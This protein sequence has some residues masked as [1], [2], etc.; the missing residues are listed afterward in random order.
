MTKQNNSPT[1]FFWNIVDAELGCLPNDYR[2]NRP[3]LRHSLQSVVN[4]FENPNTQRFLS[5]LNDLPSGG[6][7]LVSPIDGAVS[8]QCDFQLDESTLKRLNPW[9]KGP[10]NINGLKIDAEWQSHIKWDRFSPYLSQL[11]NARVLDIGCG[12]GYYMFRMLEHNPLSVLGID[13]SHLTMFQFLAIQQFIQSSILHY[14]PIGWSDLDAF[15]FFFDVVFC[16]GIMY[17]HRSPM[18]LLETIRSIGAPGGTLFFD[19]LIMDGTDEFALFPKG[20]YAKMPNVYFIPTMVCLKNMLLRSG[21]SK[22][23]VL[24]IDRTT[25]EEQRATR[26]TSEH[27]L[28]HFL[29]PKDRKKTVEGYPAPLRIALFATL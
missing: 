28:E 9:R 22:I 21:F 29:D 19:T 13:P 17:H 15:S 12:N 4:A 3:M 20:R 18:A 2:L 1:D 10:F 14:L 8:I 25:I 11:S 7:R 26:W 5:A 6:G 24:S 23:D 16:M 27:S